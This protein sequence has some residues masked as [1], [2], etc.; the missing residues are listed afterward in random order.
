[1]AGIN[2]NNGYIQISGNNQLPTA[3]VNNAN[4]TTCVDFKT[5]LE[6]Q[7][8]QKE[9]VTFSKHA[10]QRVAHRGIDV[11]ETTIERLND[12]VDQAKQKGVKDALVLGGDSMFIVN[13]ES[14]TVITALKSYEMQNNVITNIDGTVFM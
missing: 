5:L 14:R 9:Q 6:Q 1:M 8:E 12:A 10:Q 3:K 7:L 2:L 13:T 11:S 4:T